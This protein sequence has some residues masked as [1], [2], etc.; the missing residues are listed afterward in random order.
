M[1][2]DSGT[3]SQP[4]ETGYSSSSNDPWVPY[5]MNVVYNELTGVQQWPRRRSM[6][7]AEIDTAG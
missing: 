6:I 2:T 4:G 1:L 3:G 7:G 5:I